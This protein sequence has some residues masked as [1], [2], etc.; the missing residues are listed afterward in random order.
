VWPDTLYC[1]R[2][3]PVIGSLMSGS[4]LKTVPFGNPDL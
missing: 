3:G 1:V 4:L 2:P